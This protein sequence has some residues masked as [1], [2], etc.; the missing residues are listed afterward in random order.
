MYSTCEVTSSLLDTLIDHLI[1]LLTRHRTVGI[2]FCDGYCIVDN[3]R[4]VSCACMLDKETCE[5][6][7]V[8]Q[9]YPSAF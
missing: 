1:Y 5:C 3:K 2:D 8:Q 9:V 6:R 7:L 4:C